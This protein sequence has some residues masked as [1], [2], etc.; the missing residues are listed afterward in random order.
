MRFYNFSTYDAESELP[1][2]DYWKLLDAN[3]LELEECGIYFYDF[4]RVWN[5]L[6]N[7]EL[8]IKIKEKLISLAKQKGLF[9]NGIENCLSIFSMDE[10][11]E[12]LVNEFDNKILLY[13][14]TPEN[15]RRYNG[16][17][18]QFI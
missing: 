3:S 11:M 1:G 15:I 9:Y 10:L 16:D 8:K 14:S 2:G 17:I 4:M 5:G 12:L 6:K 18:F 7:E 13:L